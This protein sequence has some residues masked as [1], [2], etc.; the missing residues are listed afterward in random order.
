MARKRFGDAR[1]DPA[2]RAVAEDAIIQSLEGSE[3]L[4]EGVTQIDAELR[5]KMIAT[6][7]YFIAEQRGFVPGHAA[8]D[9]YR[10][11]AAID[12]QLPRLM[13]LD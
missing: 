3:R 9:W 13:A 5:H 12:S 11:E 7:A 4:A 1:I 8:E 2:L 6:A 10:A